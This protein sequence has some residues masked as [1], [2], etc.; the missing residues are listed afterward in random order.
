M[1]AA[2]STYERRLREFDSATNWL[3][4]QFVEF[5]SEEKFKIG[6]E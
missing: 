4:G 3:F 6:Q 2:N 1:L 5:L